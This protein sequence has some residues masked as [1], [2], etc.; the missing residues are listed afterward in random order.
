MA[1]KRGNG[2]GAIGEYGGYWVARY[3]TDDGRRKAIYGK[4]RAEV[5]DKL[6]SALRDRNLGLPAPDDRMT[7]GSF[8]LRWLNLSVK[9]RNRPSTYAAYAS[10]VHTHLVPDLGKKK[11]ARLTPEDVERFLAKKLEAGLTAT[12]VVRIRATLRRALTIALRQGLVARNVAALADPPRAKSQQ[13]EVLTAKQAQA[14]LEAIRGHRMEALFVVAIGTG[15]RQGELLGLQWPDIDF[16]GKRL[17]VRQA[18]Q[19]VDGVPTLVEPKTARSRRKVSFP[20]QALTQLRAQHEKDTEA[21]RQDPQWNPL[22]LVFTSQAGTPLDGPN[23][24]HKLQRA[25]AEA[26][27]PRIRFHDLRHTYASLL[28]AKGVSMRVIMELLGHAQISLAMNTYSHVMPEAIEDAAGLMEDI[29]T[30]ESV[31]DAQ[32]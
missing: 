19:R 25:L 24:T 13:F 14:F 32:T 30:G 15:L 31:T 11:L 1:G 4:T 8:L 3:T 2:E 12:T 26:D 10:H 27:L 5:A 23:V 9:L 18:L 20:A 7:V 6:S 22:N 17:F 16:A 29:L 28:L 21:R